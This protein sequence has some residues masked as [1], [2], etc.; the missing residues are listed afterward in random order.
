MVICRAAF[1]R[2]SE[3]N[4]CNAK[5]TKTKI[6]EEILGGRILIQLNIF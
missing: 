5:N 2:H 3:E 6:L 1:F 4:Y